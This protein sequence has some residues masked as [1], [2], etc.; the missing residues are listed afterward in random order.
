MAKEKRQWGTGSIIQEKR[1]LAIRWSETVISKDGKRRRKMKYELL[2][3]VTERKA[4]MVL[5]ERTAA[6]RRRGPVLE[7]DMPTFKDHAARWK[8]DIL[9]TYK[10]SVQLGH[11]SIIDKHLVPRFGDWLVVDD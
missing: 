7:K 5:I 4:N 8:R 6:A 10:F 3:D 2:G 11:A 9:P 1:G